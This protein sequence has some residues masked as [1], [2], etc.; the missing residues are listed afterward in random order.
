MKTETGSFRKERTRERMLAKPVS[1]RTIK[2]I[3]ERYGILRGEL[4]TLNSISL[5]GRT[6][7]DMLSDT[8][9]YVIREDM[10]HLPEEEVITCFKKRFS[11]IRLQTIL[12]YKNNK[13]HANNQ[14]AEKRQEPEQ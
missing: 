13:K 14:Q 1:E 10:D 4:V 7:D 8:F 3:S 11:T 12:D 9:E 6:E 2:I 5:E